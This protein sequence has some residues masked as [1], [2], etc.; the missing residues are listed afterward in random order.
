MIRKFVLILFLMC[1][2]GCSS[3]PKEF[4]CGDGICEVEA[5]EIFLVYS[6]T[7]APFG[8]LV[9]QVIISDENIIKVYKIDTIG[10][11]VSGSITR[12][13]YLEALNPGEAFFSL[14]FITPQCAEDT[15]KCE[16][17]LRA[18]KEIKVV[19]K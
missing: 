16:E 11:S 18:A 9:P 17:H 8:G 13:F 10:D 5:G 12:Y 19:V 15:T 14:F 3:V 7:S 2:L 6:K 4:V 1:L